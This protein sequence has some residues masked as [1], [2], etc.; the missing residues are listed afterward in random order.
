MDVVLHAMIRSGVC[1][2]AAEECRLAGLIRFIN[3]NAS[4]TV[5]KEIYIIVFCRPIHTAT[6]STT[7][8]SCFTLS[9]LV[10]FYDD[11]VVWLQHWILGVSHL[12]LDQQSAE[13]HSNRH[14]ET[15]QVPPLL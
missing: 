14:P 4:N 8:L 13:A 5:L 11:R 2:R 7:T 3:V 6:T 12:G 10:L 15:V 9:W 1:S